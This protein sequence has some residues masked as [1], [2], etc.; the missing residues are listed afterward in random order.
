VLSPPGFLLAVAVLGVLLQGGHL[1]GRR[2]LPAVRGATTLL[3][4]LFLWELAIFSGLVTTILLPPPT[5]VLDRIETLWLS[6]HLF[7]HLLSTLR[8]FLLSFGIAV[9]A[10]VGLGVLVA[11]FRPAFDLLHPLVTFVRIIPP[12][13]WAPISILWLGLGDPPAIFIVSL[14]VFFPIFVHTIRGIQSSL[15]IY[16]EVIRTL[17]G[18]RGDEIA[19]ATVPCALPVIVA[20]VRVGFGVG[21]VVLATAELIAVD[22][23]LGWLIQSAYTQVDSP[24]VLAAMTLICW[25]GVLLDGLLRQV[26]GRLVSW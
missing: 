26:E 22:N 25:M 9:A 2:A 4:L 21:W 16:R 5:L 8:R 12:P 3:L 13:A 19:S 15:P 23:G 18:T 1:L 17:G 7:W 11:S 24:T 6:G 14:A 20:G 10:G